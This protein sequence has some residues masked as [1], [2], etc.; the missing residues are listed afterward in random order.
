MICY[1]KQYP[2]T[3][4]VPCAS[5]PWILYG[6]GFVSYSPGA[7]CR[8][9][10]DAWQEDQKE[11]ISRL[12]YCRFCDG[13][14]RKN[15]GE[16]T[17]V[18]ILDQNSLFFSE[19]DGPPVRTHFRMCVYRGE[20]HGY[21]A[22]LFGYHVAHIRGGI[23]W[24]V[25]LLDFLFSVIEGGQIVEG[26]LHGPDLIASPGEGFGRVGLDAQINEDGLFIF[27]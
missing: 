17:F 27:I 1:R 10:A 6:A 13:H 2:V 21:L 7:R 24:A 20:V 3:I 12:F 22:F 14:K 19:S 9:R 11:I 15:T 8:N 26:R 25:F 4:V 5:K 23:R 16:I 18:N